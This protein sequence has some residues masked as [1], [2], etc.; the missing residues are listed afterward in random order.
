MHP[1]DW[2]DADAGLNEFLEI[3][4]GEFVVKRVGGNPHHYVARR[5]AHAF[6]EQWAGVVAGAPGNWALDSTADGRVVLGRVPDVLVDGDRILT[7]EV[8]TGV[9]DAVV[10]VWS[11]GNTLAEMNAKRSEYRRAGLPVLL[12]AFLTDAG[13]VHLE[14]LVSDGHRWTTVSAAAGEIPLTVGTPRPFTVVPK[15]L[16]RRPA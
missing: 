6:E 7:D 13:D 11:P 12:E 9:P 8:F 16:L 5:F 14:W 10:E 4:D 3:V 1:Q 15:D 2:V